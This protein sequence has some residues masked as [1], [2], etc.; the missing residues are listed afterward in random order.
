[1]AVSEMVYTGPDKVLRQ[2]RVHNKVL[3]QVKQDLKIM[4]G[5]CL[6][7]RVQEG[8]L[9]DHSATSCSHRWP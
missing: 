2:A 1:M 6:L 8:R 7:Y 5:C 4:R 3:R 9:F